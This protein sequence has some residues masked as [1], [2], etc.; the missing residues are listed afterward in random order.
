ML[1]VLLSLDF[2][3]RTSI[4]ITL[5]KIA[6]F[7]SPLPAIETKYLICKFSSKDILPSLIQLLS[8]KGKYH[9]IS[10]YEFMKLLGSTGCTFVIYLQH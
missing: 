3:I 2:Q 4:L 10:D 6:Y 5:R 8:I 1:K 7:K 9:K